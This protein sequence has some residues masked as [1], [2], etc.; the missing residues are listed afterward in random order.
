M[1]SSAKSHHSKRHIGVPDHGGMQRIIQ[2]GTIIS[3]LNQSEFELSS[4][5]DVV[6]ATYYMKPAQVR[7]LL[8]VDLQCV[9]EYKEKAEKG[10]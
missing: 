8:P 9:K 5:F 6:F 3:S 2:S 7:V 4:S 1:N 10:L